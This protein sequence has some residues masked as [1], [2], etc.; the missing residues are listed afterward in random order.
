MSGRGPCAAECARVLAERTELRPRVQIVL[1]SGLGGL[2]DRV[3]NP[4]VVPFDDLPGFPSTSV[5]GHRG[6]FVAGYLADQPVLL[7][8]GRFHFYEGLDARVVAVPVRTGHA[9]GVRTVVLTNAAGGIRRDLAP[10]NLVLIEDHVN[11]SFR[12]VLAGPSLPGEPRFPDMSR[13]YDPGLA[14]LALEAA[15]NA[16]VRLTQ[17]IYGMVLGPQFET[18]AEIRALR[19]A[20]VDMVG[21]S[22]APEA[23]V[24]R[25]LGQRVLAF[26]LIT[27][28]AS[29]LGGSGGEE[30]GEIG[31]ED[32]VAVG[33]A[34]GKV[35]GPLLEDLVPALAVG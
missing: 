4:V 26:S 21:M 1:G 28:W 23:T 5:A 11:L 10:G 18:P 22:T 3:Q 32:V 15:L 25:A 9:F 14:R 34:A 20:G 13:P 27:N 17:G 31:H 12:S 8:A 16:G 6:R 33:E 29:G 2:E 30:G 7:Q 35:L 19:A 24:A